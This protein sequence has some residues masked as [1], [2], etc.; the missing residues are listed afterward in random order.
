MTD[1]TLISVDEPKA[2]GL[3]LDLEPT[4]EEHFKVYFFGTILGLMNEVAT[5]LDSLEQA[6][7]RFPFLS[8]YTNQLAE[9][10]N[11]LSVEEALTQW[12][13]SL[14][15]SERTAEGHLP[16]RVLREAGG[17]S[18]AAML[19]LITIGLAEE[20]PRFGTVFESLQ[21]TPRQRRPTMGLLSHCW[22]NEAGDQA[23]NGYGKS[24][25]SAEFGR[26]LAVTEEHIACGP[27]RCTLTEV[28]RYGFLARRT[29]EQEKTAS[30]E[31]GRLRPDHAYDK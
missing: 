19:W 22:R 4:A 6:L 30:A 29:V 26:S 16:L 9:R 8:G 24:P 28:D 23:G 21:A 13:D 17:L 15:L 3:F 7:A 14:E 12:W 1:S 11:G 10:L 18:H 2:D 31:P 25:I 20:D 27:H 5:C